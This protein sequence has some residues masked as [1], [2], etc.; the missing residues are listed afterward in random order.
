MEKTENAQRFDFGFGVVTEADGTARVVD[1]E[2]EWQGRVPDPAGQRN[3]CEI[4]G[5]ERVLPSAPK[6]DLLNALPPGFVP[7]RKVT[8][9]QLRE[10]YPRKQER[11]KPYTITLASREAGYASWTDSNGQRWRSPMFE[12]GMQ[13]VDVKDGDPW[14]IGT[15][16]SYDM[17]AGVLTLQPPA[18]SAEAEPA[19]PSPAGH[20]SVRPALAG[21]AD[22][23]G[24]LLGLALDRA[25]SGAEPVAAPPEAVPQPARGS[26]RTR[27]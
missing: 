14:P 20:P 25:S 13:L 1:G 19:A 12:P 27:R 22:P 16:L 2:D 9:E 23:A 6:P 11:Y 4:V 3:A 24:L 15:V 26:F 8:R 21:P 17:D 10:M 7:V 5:I 18:S